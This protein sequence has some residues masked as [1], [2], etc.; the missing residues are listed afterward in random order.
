MLS[1]AAVLV[2]SRFAAPMRGPD[3]HPTAVRHATP[4]HDLRL[5]SSADRFSTFTCHMHDDLPPVRVRPVFP[6][7]DRLPGAKHQPPVAHRD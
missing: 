7:V 3:Q 5:S 6:E 2:G 4:L 1:Q